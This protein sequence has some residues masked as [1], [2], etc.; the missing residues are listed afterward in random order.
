VL[1]FKKGI[2]N[3]AQKFGI[4]IVPVSIVGSYQFFQT[5]NWLLYPGKI[6]VYLHDTIDTS[7]VSR[8]EVEALRQQVQ[9]IVA[10]PVE[11][12]IGDWKRQGI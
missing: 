3:L 11:E 9:D 6:F 10:R 1:P 4:P 8:G 7:K 2:F 5:G 12:S